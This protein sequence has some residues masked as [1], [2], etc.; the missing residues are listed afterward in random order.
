[1]AVTVARRHGSLQVIEISDMATTDNYCHQQL[2]D[3]SRHHHHHH[4]NTPIQ[5]PVATGG[6]GTL[7]VQD[8]CRGGNVAVTGVYR[9]P[10]TAPLRKMSVDLIRTYKHINEVRQKFIT[11]IGGR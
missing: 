6:A 5:Q 8:P 1:M 11:D 3:A 4:H 10:A 7:A 9:N 2:P